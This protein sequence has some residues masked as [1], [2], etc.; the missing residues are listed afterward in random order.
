MLLLG[1]CWTM[2]E[3]TRVGAVFLRGNSI[4]E[5][6]S[7]ADLKA[8]HTGEHRI[9]VERVTPGL[10][11]A[12]V[13]PTLWGAA[14]SALDL[15]GL[16]DPRDVAARVAERAAGLP[17]GVWI[18]GGGYLLD[19]YPDAKLL[20]AAAGNRPVLL[21]SRDLHSAWV[22]SAALAAAGLSTRTPDPPGGVIVRD[23][24]GNPTGSLLERA[25]DLVVQTAPRPG[26]E[27][28][29]RGLAD[30]AS[31]GLTAAH[32]MP[33]AGLDDLP[34]AES[35]A[36]SGKLPLR[37]WWAVGGRQWR[38]LEPGWRGEDLDVV[39]V[40][41]FADGS[42][43][44]RTAWMHEP[45]SDGTSGMPVDSL[46]ALRD[47]LAAA[48]AAG[49]RPGAHAVGTRAVAVL[50]DI[51]DELA[52]RLPVPLRIEHAQH[53]RAAD[54]ARMARLP[55]AA[56][57]Q[58]AHLD[59]DAELVRRLLPGRESEAFPLRALVDAGVPLALGS[60][61]PVVEPD[62]VATLCAA[63][64]HPLLPASSLAEHEALVAATRGAARVAGW[65]DVGVVVPGARADL[66][67]W[68]GGRPV[69]RVWRG[70]LE[71]LPG[72]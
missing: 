48:V 30:L 33:F 5:V 62:P 70:E 18:R 71:W 29:T 31:R 17:R 26:P 54:V 1:E 60:D 51:V 47:E 38:Q 69:G 57:V 40:K 6:G 14:L 10:H 23:T 65:D 53:V 52:G 13:H 8:R 63:V 32:S 28:L 36:S 35:L 9:E 24:A 72:R 49:W 3:P 58:P 21:T 61:A 42:L 44:S 43:E 4:A 15:T 68:E 12:H 50:L 45:Y 22:S 34:W 55:V 16:A 37:L 7:A 11:D 39:A 27:D 64:A 59:R 67:L 56:S 41:L 19:H 20:D 25:V 46:S 2:A 66:T